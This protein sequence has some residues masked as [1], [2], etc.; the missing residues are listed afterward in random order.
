LYL[1]KTL[2]KYYRGEEKDKG[3]QVWVLDIMRIPLADTSANVWRRP[4]DNG[5]SSEATWSCGV[6]DE[7][8][9]AAENT[10]DIN[11]SLLYIS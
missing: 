7:P 11:M 8:G 2:R 6:P 5:V 4:P 1:R 10:I 9:A 3:A